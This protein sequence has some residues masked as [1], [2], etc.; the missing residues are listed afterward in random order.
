MDPALNKLAYILPGL[1]DAGDRIRAIC[2]R[3]RGRDSLGIERMLLGQ[4]TPIRTTHQL[5]TRGVHQRQNLNYVLVAIASDR[6][7]C[8]NTQLVS[9]LL[10]ELKR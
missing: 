10:D 6:C 2:R 1:G 5:V 3:S 9:N 8:R 4:F 7:R